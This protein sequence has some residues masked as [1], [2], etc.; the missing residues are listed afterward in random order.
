MGEGREY[1]FLT[2]FV[3]IEMAIEINSIRSLYPKDHVNDI[4]TW[5]K[6]GLLKYVNK[7]KALTFTTQMQSQF[8]HTWTEK[9]KSLIY[10]I[11]KNFPNVKLFR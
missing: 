5:I 3:G 1:T 6:D 9:V 4:V 2:T 8:P 10:N 11:I 7:E